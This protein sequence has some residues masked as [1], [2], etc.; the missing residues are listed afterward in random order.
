MDRPLAMDRLLSRPTTYLLHTWCAAVLRAQAHQSS[1]VFIVDSIRHEKKGCKDCQHESL[2]L[3]VIPVDR[4]NNP[5]VPE[6]IPYYISIGRGIDRLVGRDSVVDQVTVVSNDANL[7]ERLTT[8][9]LITLT[10]LPEHAP[11]LSD[12]SKILLHVS[13]TNPHYNPLT[14]HRYWFCRASYAVVITL[15]PNNTEE[16]GKKSWKRLC[17]LAVFGLQ[18]CGDHGIQSVIAYSQYLRQWGELGAAD[19]APGLSTTR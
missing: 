18:Y 1:P 9:P 6:H 2:L 3:R 8:P 17:F 12:L 5:V 16:K 10:W 4:E 13:L 19:G 14:S 11:R 7:Q 15:Y